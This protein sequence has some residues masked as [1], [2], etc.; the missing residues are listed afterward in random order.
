[1]KKVIITGGSG[2]IG[3]YLVKKFLKEGY[4]VSVVDN[5]LR[6]NLSRLASCKNEI[7]LLDLDVRDEVSL[8]KV[9]KNT[10]LVVHLAAINGTENF[11]EHPELV[12]DVGILGAISVI[13]ACRESNVPDLIFASSAEV[14]QSA[15]IIP[16]DETVPLTLPN[17]FSPR[18]S[19][20]GSKIAS[21]LIAFNYGRDHFRKLQI[22]RPH[23][24]YGPDMGWKHVIPNFIVKALNLKDQKFN[25]K[26]FEIEGDGSQTRA[27]CYVE[28]VVDGIL[29]MYK[30]GENNEIYHIGNDSEISIEN[31]ANKVCKALSV[32]PNFSYIN[33]YDDGPKSRCPDINKIR[34]IG[35]IPKIDLEE[36]LKET[37]NWY[38]LQYMKKIDNRLL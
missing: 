17:S 38:T 30:F 34:K 33:K 29:T 2:F 9:F 28:D 16:T 31:L 13:K 1:M 37:I 19:Y 22:F 5:L 4:S 10:D 32:E 6:G 27:F 11:Y 12:L 3:S 26:K 23:N 18:F 14:Y 25:K 21:E 8:K 35:Y 24:I 36:G 20:G 7:N 15:E